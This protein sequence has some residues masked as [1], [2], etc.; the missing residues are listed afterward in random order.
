[1]PVGMAKAWAAE[2]ERG[3]VVG[4]GKREEKKEQRKQRGI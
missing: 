1:M 4:I 2:E 3:E